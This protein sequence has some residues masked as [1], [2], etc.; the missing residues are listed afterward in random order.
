MRLD[1]VLKV[2]GWHSWESLCGH[3]DPYKFCI[4][5]AWFSNTK[6]NETISKSIERSN[7]VVE[8]EVPTVGPHF[9]NFTYF[10]DRAL[11]GNRTWTSLIHLPKHLFNYARPILKLPAMGVAWRSS[12]QQLCIYVILWNR[13]KACVLFEANISVAL[14][15][16][17][18]ITE[19]ICF[20]LIN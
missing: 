20:K 5:H 11:A 2:M 3:F 15:G 14:H 8:L 9:F 18:N 4:S 19:D 12:Q 13:Y 1:Y 7:L 6:L 10:W 17:V 16:F